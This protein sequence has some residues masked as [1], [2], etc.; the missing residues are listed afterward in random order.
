L[1]S[2]SGG[3][4]ACRCADQGYPVIVQRCVAESAKQ[5]ALAMRGESQGPR[6][7]MKAGYSDELKNAG[8]EAQVAF[9]ELK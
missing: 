3:D 9:V 4:L 7:R 8:A 2:E 6:S 5:I 1:L